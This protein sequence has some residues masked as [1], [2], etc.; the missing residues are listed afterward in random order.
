MSA[1]TKAIGLAKK[2]KHRY[3]DEI[4]ARTPVYLSPV[5]RIERVSLPMMQEHPEYKL[6]HVA[7]KSGFGC[8]STFRRAFV[9]YTGQM[10]GQGM[11]VHEGAN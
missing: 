8:V 10:P 5:R 3:Q 9:K 6:E 1:V 4:R 11:T 7:E 2:L